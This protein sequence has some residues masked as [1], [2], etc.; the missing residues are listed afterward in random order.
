MSVLL[1]DDERI[2]EMNARDRGVDKPTDVL[3]YPML[4]GSPVG[5][6]EHAPMLLG[7]IVISVRT[8]E[9]QAA[10]RGISLEDELA[11]LA[12]HGCLHLIGYEDETASGAARMREKETEILGAALI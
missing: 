11:L 5:A 12:V 8:A 7:D 4:E 6:P 1:V 10:A 2:H 9:R 3:S